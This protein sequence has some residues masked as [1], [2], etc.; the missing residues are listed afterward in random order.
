M[1]PLP[2]RLPTLPCFVDT[3]QKNDF[4]GKSC[5]EFDKGATFSCYCN[6][7]LQKA[8][9]EDGLIFGAQRL[10]Q[11]KDGEE[12]ICKSFVEQ[13]LLAEMLKNI[14]GLFIVVVNLVLELVMYKLTELE[15]HHSK[16]QFS[17]SLCM[18]IFLAQFLNT[19]LVLMLVN[20]RFPNNVNF[21]MGET[22]GV[23]AGPYDDFSRAWY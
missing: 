17:A 15:R 9:A 4:G 19:A 23:M 14:Q 20:A 13:F 6:G 1:C 21:P 3:W 12:P 18:K 7:Q 10:I 5:R 2:P 8:I 11:G 22:L 16:S